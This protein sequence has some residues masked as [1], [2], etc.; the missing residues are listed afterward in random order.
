MSSLAR[1][2]IVIFFVVVAGVLESNYV[3]AGL[4]L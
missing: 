2:A 3:T 4:S 1:L